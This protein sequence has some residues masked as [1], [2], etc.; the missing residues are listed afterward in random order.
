MIT[1]TQQ[2]ALECAEC[3]RQL[4]HLETLGA[5]QQTGTIQA[6]P[7]RVCAAKPG[8]VVLREGVRNESGP[9]GVR[10]VDEHDVV[11]EVSSTDDLVEIHWRGTSEDG[12]I[13]RKHTVAQAVHPLD[14][15]HAL[16]LAGW[17]LEGRIEK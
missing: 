3:G 1:L 17:T 15:L 14:I 11:I 16:T 6:V 8:R 7:C 12:E 4:Q 9:G 10:L 5:V 2:L 13:I